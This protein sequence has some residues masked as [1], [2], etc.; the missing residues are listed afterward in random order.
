MKILSLIYYNSNILLQ[1]NSRIS[2]PLHG[3]KY[4]FASF[5]QD[6]A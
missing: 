3:I 5:Q 2:W 4:L 1:R 6:I